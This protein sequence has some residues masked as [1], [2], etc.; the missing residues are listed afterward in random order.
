MARSRQSAGYGDAMRIEVLVFDGCPNA[1]PAVQLAR[2]VAGEA[3]IDPEIEV[4]R[5][6]DLEAAQT[7]RFLGSPSIRI[8]GADVEPGADGRPPA[9]ACRIYQGAGGPSGLP[10]REWVVGALCGVAHLA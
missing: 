1:E 5:I 7:Q 6:T 2:D 8:E 10:D 4:V 3:G 9:Y